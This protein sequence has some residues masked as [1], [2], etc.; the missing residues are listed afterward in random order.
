MKAER[1]FAIPVANKSRSKFV[2]RP[3]G[4]IPSIAFALRMPSKVPMIA[5]KIVYLIPVSVVIPEKSGKVTA[6]SK[7]PGTLTKKLLPN[8]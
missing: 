7:L 8:S 6:F 3:Q 1:V 5:N 4:S 2:F